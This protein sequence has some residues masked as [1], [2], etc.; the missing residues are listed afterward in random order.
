MTGCKSRFSVCRYVSRSTVFEGRMNKNYQISKFEDITIIRMMELPTRNDLISAVIEVKSFDTSSLRMW[1]LQK[2][3]NLSADDLQVIASEAL[4]HLK[5]PGRMAVVAPT[6]LSYGLSRMFEVFRE[7]EGVK[8]HS[9]RT[10][11]DAVKWLKSYS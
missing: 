10:E 1:V 3:V 2:G 5:G 8:T 9:F 4:K 7:Q 6:D 11:E